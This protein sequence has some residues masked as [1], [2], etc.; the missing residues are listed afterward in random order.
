MPS[1]T[2]DDQQRATYLTLI[3]VFLSLVACYSRRMV[4][5]AAAI[6]SPGLA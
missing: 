6:A 4:P 1:R 5:P 3:A 2:A